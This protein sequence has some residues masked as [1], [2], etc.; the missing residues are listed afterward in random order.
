MGTS[1]SCSIVLAPTGKP[2]YWAGETISGNVILTIKKSVNLQSIDVTMIGQHTYR[3]QGA[4][5]SSPHTEIR[6][7]YVQNQPLFVP[8]TNGIS[9]NEVSRSHY[10]TICKNEALFLNQCI[11]SLLSSTRRL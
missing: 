6:N 5:G 8:A 10:S 3:Y 9:Y 11:Y 1:T 7:F 4:Q 2:F